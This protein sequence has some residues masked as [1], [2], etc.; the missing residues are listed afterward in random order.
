MRGDS[1]VMMLHG[2]IDESYRDTSNVYVVAGYLADVASWVEFD[3]RWRESMR[4]LEIESIGL[5][6][7]DC[8][9]RQRPYDGM[10][11]AKRRE[12]I[13]QMVSDIDASRLRGFI[14]AIDTFAL[15]KYEES[16]AAFWSPPAKKYHRA[17]IYATDICVHS[18]FVATEES[19]EP[20]TFFADRNDEFAGRC[21]EWY[22]ARSSD[23]SSPF[24]GR[25]GNFEAVRAEQAEDLGV[26]QLERN[27]VER[28]VGCE[29][30]C[31]VLDL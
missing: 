10:D 16:I 28:T 4:R 20:V 5:H 3:E 25:Y 19:K 6:S 24:H 13:R 9:R 31:D 7:T 2:Y 12:I 8:Q 22:T 21:L 18:M 26:A 23:T 1:L 27:A 15:Q 14:A 29:R 30:L 17:H 11:E